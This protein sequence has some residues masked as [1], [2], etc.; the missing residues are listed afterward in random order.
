MQPVTQQCPLVTELVLSDCHCIDDDCLVAFFPFTS[1]E[2]PMARRPTAD[3]A[4]QQLRIREL[5]LRKC[6]GILAPR[7]H[8]PYL[9]KLHVNWSRVT[10]LAKLQLPF[11]K[12]VDLTGCL[13]LHPESFFKFLRQCPH[14][15]SLWMMGPSALDRQDV[16]DRLCC[17]VPP[18][19]TADAAPS[20]GLQGS[21]QETPMAQ[22]RVLNMSGLRQLELRHVIAVIAHCRRLHTLHIGGC[23]RLSKPLVIELIHQHPRILFKGLGKLGQVAE[24]GAVKAMGVSLSG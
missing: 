2:L 7:I 8:S 24:G 21:A 3:E 4:Q 13:C 9:T 17:S 11:L 12:T 18:L 19:L 1:Q 23:V 6:V 15:R 16:L 22:L 20:A 10:S 14:L 5:T